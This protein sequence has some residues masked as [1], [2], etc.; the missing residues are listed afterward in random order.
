MQLE[1]S[2]EVFPLGELITMIAGSSVTGALSIQGPHTGMIY[3]QDGRPYHAVYHDEHGTEAV[4]RMFELRKAS[5]RFVAGEQHERVTIY[6][7]PWALVSYAERQAQMWREVRH[8]FPSIACVPV[9]REHLPP[10][11][12]QISEEQWPV[13]AAVD[14]TR[15]L[16]GIAT[17]L[18]QVPVE[19]GMALCDLAKQRLISIEMPGTRRVHQPVTPLKAETASPSP[20]PEA[21]PASR[22]GLLARLI[23]NRAAE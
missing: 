2:L 19:V 23:A 16:E 7:E 22:N 17:Y 15:S 1:G 5:F 14:G 4:T 10:S 8:F 20:Q 9:I 6:Y 12:V 21:P 18:S 3:C 13:L 11:E